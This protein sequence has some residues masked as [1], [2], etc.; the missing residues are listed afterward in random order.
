VY[1]VFFIQTTAL[2]Y[3]RYPRH[4][5]VTV[6]WICSSFVVSLKVSPTK[7]TPNHLSTLLLTA[8]A[9]GVRL[10]HLGIAGSAKMIRL[11]EDITH[12]RH[13]AQRPKQE[14]QD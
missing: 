8:I 11:F 5:D 12:E 10:S 3:E 2:Q 6:T 9:K 14:Q 13:P 1:S 7:S 4:R